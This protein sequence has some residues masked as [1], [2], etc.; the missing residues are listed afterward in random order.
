MV[1]GGHVAESSD[2]LFDLV[3][4]IVSEE[5]IYYRDNI[6]QIK[7]IVTA[8]DLA[9][10]FQDTTGYFLRIGEIE[11]RLRGLIDKLPLT[12]IEEKSDKK[13]VRKM[14]FQVLET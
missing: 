8:T 3:P 11:S 2:D 7:G 12:V 13:I 5:Y 4:I 14:A 10:T 1:G 9:Q 6:Q